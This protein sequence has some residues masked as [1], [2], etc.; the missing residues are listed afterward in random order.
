MCFFL[1]DK[2]RMMII[3]SDSV[4]L[5]W[6]LRI[7]ISNIYPG[8]NGAA[9]FGIPLW[10]LHWLRTWGFNSAIK[11]QLRTLNSSYFF[12]I[13]NCLPISF[14]IYCVHFLPPWRN[15]VHYP[16]KTFSLHVSGGFESWGWHWFVCIMLHILASEYFSLV[17]FIT[18]MESIA[19]LPDHLHLFHTDRG[20]L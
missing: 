20:W 12:F 6:G 8:D 17:L 5:G 9:G 16:I 13:T 7:C 4:C 3:V 19:W 18:N 2:Q 15:F 1:I 11:P 10:K 14:C